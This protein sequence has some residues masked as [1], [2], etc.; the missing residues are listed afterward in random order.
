M[1][2]VRIDKMEPYEPNVSGH[3]RQLFGKHHRAGRRVAA[4]YF[5]VFGMRAGAACRRPKALHTK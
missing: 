2:P 3:Q 5:G 1:A 4:R